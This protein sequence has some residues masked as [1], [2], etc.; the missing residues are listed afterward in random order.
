M[1]PK[2]IIEVSSGCVRDISSDAELDVMILDYD[3]QGFDENEL[4]EIPLIGDKA[5]CSIPDVDVSA[6]RVRNLY[7]VIKKDLELSK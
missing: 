4:I 1:K 5:N 6:K 2:V 7:D 3:V